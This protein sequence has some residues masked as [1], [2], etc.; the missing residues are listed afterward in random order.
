M[1]ERSICAWA[2]D[3]ASMQSSTSRGRR[4]W[5]SPGPTRG[6]AETVLIGLHGLPK[7]L[8]AQPV[9][10]VDG[11]CFYDEDIVA[12]YRAIAPRSSGSSAACSTAAG[13]STIW[14]LPPPTFASSSSFSSSCL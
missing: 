10:L 7:H 5:V 2:D 14:S 4:M 6:A 13:D 11:D 9:M 1:L 8:R 3:R 12:T